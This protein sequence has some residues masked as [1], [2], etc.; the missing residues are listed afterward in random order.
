MLKGIAAIS[1]VI[2]H[3][4]AVVIKGYVRTNA[5][6][7]S[8]IRTEQWEMLYKCMR[9]IG[10]TAFP[11]FAFLLVEG[12]IHTKDRRQ[13]ALRLLLFALLSE[14]PYNLAQGGG[15]WNPA[16]QNVLFT[17][18]LGFLLLCCIEPI[19]RQD[20]L[21]EW[22]GFLF[23]AMAVLAVCGIAYLGRTDY[24]Y[25]GIMLIFVFYFFRQYRIAS[26]IAG[27]CVFS[28]TPLS[29]P[30]FLLIP[31]YNGRRGRKKLRLFYLFYPLHLLILYGVNVV[32]HWKI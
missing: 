7:L 12:F 1:M 26:A 17:L 29:F 32:F 14:I 3:I 27:F 10:R 4:G 19:R 5:S 16:K 9:A 31:F 11:L 21:P 13:Y 24:S 15:L 30:A 28:R 22:I 8:R 20:I 6:L 18:L 2:D 25:R 23:C